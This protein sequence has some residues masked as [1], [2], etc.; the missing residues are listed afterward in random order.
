MNILFISK[1][2][3][4][5]GLW[6]LCKREGAKV[7]AYIHERWAR[8]IADGLIDKV[9]T[10]EQGLK[11]KPDVIVIDLNGMGK[12]GDDLQ[13]DG[14]KVVGGGEF[15]NRFEMDRGWAV[16]VAQ[17]FGVKVPKTTE[18]KDVEE[19]VS[20][21]KKNKKAYAIKCDNNAG[22]E[23]ASYVASDQ[24]DMLDYLAQQKESGKISGC[25]FI[26]QEVVKGAEISTE[27]FFSN[28]VP[29]PSSINT[30]WETK[31]FLAGELGPRTGAEVSVV[32]HYQGHRKDF[33][34][35]TVGKILPLL[36]Y[37]NYT[38]AMD[39]NSIVSEVDHECYF[40]EA[41][42]RLGY[43]A[44]FAFQN[45]LAMPISEYF[46][47]LSIGPFTVPYRSTWS[48][49]LKISI[50]PYPTS[51]PNEKASEETYGEQEGVRV[52]GEYG[53]DFIPLD[54]MKGKKT[55]LMC[56]GVTCIVGECL[57]RGNSILEA[58]KASQKVF[59]SV[60]V[61]NAQGRYTDGI[62][63]IWKRVQKLKQFGFDIPQISAG[64]GRSL[65]PL[66]DMKPSA[67]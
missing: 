67:V 9:E 1:E 45:L 43:S 3:D 11:E 36:K 64:G 8:R 32:C 25:T 30:T 54:C 38:G 42:P 48:S 51:I 7:V 10:I 33:Y 23:S 62:E 53:K 24:E 18:F 5:A 15:A 34:D 16:K 2:G 19:A 58:W 21:I 46:R 31:R 52:N 44:C 20:F 59:K 41:T 60:E 6:H 66:R 40:L 65:I 56:S 12:I 35:K 28:G 17:Q 13:K 61:P 27:C 63:D 57:G 26:I 22:G 29:I 39:F 37:Q 55:E 14:W 47:R 4:S 50:P 49:S